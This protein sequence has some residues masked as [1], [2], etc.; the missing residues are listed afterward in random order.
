MKT[1]ETAP[2]LCAAL[3][4][5]LSAGSA[6]AGVLLNAGFEDG[7]ISPWTTTGGIGVSS[8]GSAQATDGV[9]V[10]LIGFNSTFEP[11]S[12]TLS[13]TFSTAGAGM[14]EYTF[15]LG[16]SEPFCSCNDV[17]LTFTAH[18]DGILLADGLPP[19]D[20]AGGGNPV[21][22]RLLRHYAGSVMLD[23]GMHTMSFSFARGGS[24]FG[25]APFFVLDAV[26]GTSLAEPVTG[27]VPE[28]ASWALMIAGFGMVGG[29]LRRRRP[30][31]RLVA[32]A[33]L[34]RLRNSYRAR[35]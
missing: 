17:A 12:G 5:A 1:S 20:P 2:A 32:Y 26:E 11:K 35:W 9:R 7:T 13:Q 34:P 33:A 21:A 31:L 22:T 25:R 10:G 14:F 8:L 18:I 15:D 19:F 28:P 4:L 23:A 30:G 29:A 27:G 16:R 24:G 6:H 3:T